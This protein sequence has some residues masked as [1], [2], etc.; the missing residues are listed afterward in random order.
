[1]PF[2]CGIRKWCPKP[3]SST[4]HVKQNSGSCTAV[5]PENSLSKTRMAERM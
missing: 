2:M 4:N 3:N 5:L 1:M